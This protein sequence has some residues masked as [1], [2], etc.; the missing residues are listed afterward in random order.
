MLSIEQIY[1][2]VGRYINE[3]IRE[4]WR[5]QGHPLTGSF[6]NS[7]YGLTS[8]NGVRMD[9][10]GYGAKHGKIV[11]DGL[12]PNEIQDNMKYK[13]VVYFTLRGFSLADA[14]K[15]AV[16]TMKKWRQEGMST[17]ASG[18]FSLTGRRQNFIEE[19]IFEHES[20][21]DDMLLNLFDASVEEHY[22]LTKNETV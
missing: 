1:Q 20:I 5:L 19:A 8:K 2:T 18:R 10:N 9:F 14:N 13:L 17:E 15:F 3:L 21:I 7:L 6:E 11:N 16:L 4:E 12:Q 22:R